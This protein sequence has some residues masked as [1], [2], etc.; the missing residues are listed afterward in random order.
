MAREIPPGAAEPRDLSDYG[1]S[2]NLP[3]TL[4]Q[5]WERGW[6]RGDASP[7]E[8]TIL[9]GSSGAVTVM[10]NPLVVY[11]QCVTSPRS[12]AELVD[13]LGANPAI[14]VT[15][16]TPI[17]VGGLL[18]TRLDLSIAPDGEALLR[19]CQTQWEKMVPVMASPHGPDGTEDYFPVLFWLDPADDQG[20]GRDRRGE[21]MRVYVLDAGDGR[22]IAI[23]ITAEEGE[24]DRVVEQATPLIEGFTFGG[25]G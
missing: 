3:A 8:F 4:P 16:S 5:G 18:G 22:P 9:A 12:A 24:F 23:L 13:W 20:L 19:S 14:S 10:S 2:A 1:F 21:R 6:A 15:D 11:A 25:A 17:A 7:Y